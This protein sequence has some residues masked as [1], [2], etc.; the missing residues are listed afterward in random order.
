MSDTVTFFTDRSGFS[1]SW[2]TAL[3]RH[4][5]AVRVCAPDELASVVERNAA[6]VLDARSDAF[7]EDELLAAAGFV[8][9]MG[10]IPVVSL[11]QE[12]EADVEDV[13]LEICDGRVSRTDDD[14]ERLA[15]AMQRLLDRERCRRFEFVTVSPR[16]NEVLAILGNGHS[17]LLRRPLAAEDDGADVVAITM[18]DDAASAVLELDSGVTFEVQASSFG[19]D[20]TTASTVPIDGSRLGA[21]L[22]E[23]RL[24]AGLTQAEL[25]RR[26]GIHRP[27]I[28][29]VEAGR[30]TPS[31]ETLSRLANAIGVPT[32]RVLSED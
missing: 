4:G 5:F 11:D 14:V 2:R 9:A 19:N 8:R 31:L 22:R 30:H 12:Q 15:A 3:E 28:A 23:L 16:G 21:R 26:T 1:T 29:R 17:V 18:S 7:D 24:E 13:I 32:T 20:N 25:A 27:N 10:G 6:A